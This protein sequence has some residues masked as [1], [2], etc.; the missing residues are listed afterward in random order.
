VA[1]TF[2]SISNQT[3]DNVEEALAILLRIRLSLP[4]SRW[5]YHS[6]VSLV[7]PDLFF[8][9]CFAV[10]FLLARKAVIFGLLLLNPLKQLQSFSEVLF[11]F[12]MDA[13]WKLLLAL[14]CARLHICGELELMKS[15]KA[16]SCTRLD[17][18]GSRVIVRQS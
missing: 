7:L 17:L 14:N 8:W 4:L 15:L 18:S 1:L 12:S 16:C 5:R 6:F 11:D 3:S 10:R 9:K 13:V 2:R